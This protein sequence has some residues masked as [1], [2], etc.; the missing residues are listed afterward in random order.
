MDK[1]NIKLISWLAGGCA[2]IVLVAACCIGAYFAYRY[3]TQRGSQGNIT[4]T[5]PGL[6]P[7]VSLAGQLSKPITISV[8][9]SSSVTPLGEDVTLQVPAGAF[10]SPTTITVSQVDVAFDQVDADVVGSR[11][12][13]IATPGE[14]GDLGSPVVLEIPA[15]SSTMSV[16]KWDGAEWQPVQV[17]PGLT[18]RVEITHFSGSAFGFLEWWAARSESLGDVMDT[19]TLEGNAATRLR[20]EQGD[21]DTQAF[22]GVGDQ[23]V[24]SHDEMCA[25]LIDVVGQ[26]NNTD[27]RKFPSDAN[28]HMDELFMYLAE[29]DYPSANPG[30]FWNLTK[31]SMEEIN[32]QVLSAEDPLSPAQVLKIAIEANHGNVPLGILAANNY[33]KDKTYRGRSDLAPNGQVKP[34]YAAPIS[35]LQ[36]WRTDSNI[37]PAGYYDKM[38][39]LYHIFSAMVAETWFPTR[40][41]GDAAVSAEALLRSFRS[42]NDRPDPQKGQADQCGLDVGH[43]LR[44]HAAGSTQPQPVNPSGSGGMGT[45]NGGGNWHGVPCAEAEGTFLYRWSV[46][47]LF[48][49]DTGGV[50][51]TLKFHDCPGGGRVLYTV[52][53][54]LPANSVY[55]LNGE[56]QEGGGDLFDSSP[57]NLIFTF[58]SSTVTID[59]DLAP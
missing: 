58:D 3:F 19:D 14:V 44:D 52:E 50:K 40:A 25:D 30:Y 26:F 18:T 29:G 55:T 16:M 17:T 45:G 22:N 8:D 41:S 36:S 34:E 51:G 37:A 39:P 48:N 15:I 33:L 42:G 57:E 23:A 49:P 43:W 32:D 47:L 24:S 13:W 38:G 28:M 11:F 27:N 54:N 6:A 53:G 35:H 59:P 1:K 12:Y 56:K 4:Q 10:A 2:A 5:F 31:D 20:I 7:Y 21:E 9:G 46:D